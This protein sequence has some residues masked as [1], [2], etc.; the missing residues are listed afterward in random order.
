MAKLWQMQG[1]NVWFHQCKLFVNLTFNFKIL[2]PVLV[3]F[4]VI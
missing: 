2:I 1:M 4:V 3:K